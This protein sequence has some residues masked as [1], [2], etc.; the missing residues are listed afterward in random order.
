MHWL[1]LRIIF[2]KLRSFADEEEFILYCKMLA[3]VFKNSA[4]SSKEELSAM[5][6]LVEYMVKVFLEK[7]FPYSLMIWMD[8]PGRHL[9]R[10]FPTIIF[11]IEAA[12]RRIETTHDLELLLHLGMIEYFLY[13][14]QCLQPSFYQPNVFGPKTSSSK[15]APFENTQLN[16]GLSLED[17]ISSNLLRNALSLGRMDV[18]GSSAFNTSGDTQ[19]NHAPA[20]P[21][22]YLR[23]EEFS[24]TGNITDYF[25]MIDLSDAGP[26]T[27]S[28]LP[29]TPNSQAWNVSEP[30]SLL[31]AAAP[32]TPCGDPVSSTSPGDFGFLPP[33]E[34]QQAAPSHSCDAYTLAT[35]DNIL[36]SSACPCHID[37]S[38]ESFGMLPPS[39]VLDPAIPVSLSD[40]ISN[41][42]F[43]QL[44]DLT[45][46]FSGIDNLP[47]AHVPLAL[48]LPT[49]LGTPRMPRLSPFLPHTPTQTVQASDSGETVFYNCSSL[50]SSGSGDE[51]VTG[52]TPKPSTP[53]TKAK[54]KGKGKAAAVSP[55]VS[56]QRINSLLREKRHRSCASVSQWV[57][58]VAK[59]TD[60]DEKENM[61][62]E[63]AGS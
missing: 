5:V 19:P 38:P 52:A 36:A 50:P 25:P 49:D 62:F 56:L 6:H 42:D 40:L 13:G 2:D 53:T 34:P 31:D 35:L 8:D 32:I 10:C 15:E 60:E 54:D 11:T 48:P 4:N 58:G 46:L 57:D 27:S 41:P 47:P 55:A 14:D 9:P 37:S 39:P 33:S 45:D 51:N 61:F 28:M 21:H 29:Q 26:V 7:V 63:S 23:E 12:H 3:F 30:Y 16:P 17:R 18:P 20:P 22:N 1:N 43:T 24:L 59:A 44:G